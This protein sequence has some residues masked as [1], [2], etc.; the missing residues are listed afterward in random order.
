ML[1]KIIV[2]DSGGQEHI[3]NED[4]GEVEHHLELKDDNGFV[5]ITTRTF[6]GAETF[7]AETETTFIC[8]RR[9]DA[10]YGPY[11]V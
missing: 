11:E 6:N 3:F 8:P 2:T 5:T 9:V 4:D 7:E 10:L 1:L